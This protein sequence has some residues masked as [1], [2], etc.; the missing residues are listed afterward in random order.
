[1]ALTV[2]Q[3][4]AQLETSQARMMALVINLHEGGARTDSELD[5]SAEQMSG[6][7]DSLI[8]AWATLVLD[9]RAIGAMRDAI[10]HLGQPERAAS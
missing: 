10:A 5:A 3:A 9:G 4:F 1:M 2:Q 6:I 8:E 7:A